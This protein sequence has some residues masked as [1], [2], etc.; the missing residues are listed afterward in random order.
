MSLWHHC[1]RE[2]PVR[3]GG[4]GGGGDLS[5]HW[6]ASLVGSSETR[7]VHLHC[8]RREQAHR[9]VQSVGSHT[10]VLVKSLIS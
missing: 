5:P 3:H 2:N 7:V 8:G 10:P 9:H 1:H 6:D 4:S